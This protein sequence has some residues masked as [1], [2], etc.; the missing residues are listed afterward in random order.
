MASGDPEPDE[1]VSGLDDNNEDPDQGEGKGTGVHI[2]LQSRIPVRVALLG[3]ELAGYP[4]YGA[5][6]GGFLRPGGTE[7][8]RESD[9]SEV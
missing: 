2:F 7:I 3:G 1:G 4:P 5:G 6:T 8:G 9:T